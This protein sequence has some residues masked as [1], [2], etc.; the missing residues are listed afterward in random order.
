MYLIPHT[1]CFI[2]GSN[3]KA[4][5]LIMKSFVFWIKTGHAVF[6]GITLIVYRHHKTDGFPRL[7]GTEL[8]CIFILNTLG[9]VVI[10]SLDAIARD[11]MSW[12]WKIGISL[13]WSLWL[14]FYA[15]HW[16]LVVES[17]EMEVPVIGKRMNLTTLMSNFVS[18]QAIFFFDQ[19][20]TAYTKG[21]G[22]SILLT[23]SPFEE[24]LTTKDKEAGRSPSFAPSEADQTTISGFILND[25]RMTQRVEQNGQSSSSE[26]ESG[27]GDTPDV[28]SELNGAEASPTPASNSEQIQINYKQ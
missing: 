9:T 3:K 4:F 16:L 7:E 26:K 6:Y 27:I 19:S 2:L 8:I 28:D 21:P 23:H 10:G 11:Y 24:W 20:F 15:V 5:Q 12:G 25:K 17:Y 22:R 1:I 13:F 14:A 18:V